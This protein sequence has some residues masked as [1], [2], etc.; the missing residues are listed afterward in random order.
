MSEAEASVHPHLPIR[1]T[2]REALLMEEVE[3]NW[4]RWQ[5][6]ARLPLHEEEIR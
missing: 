2:V 5:V 3:P 4:G 1:S 6:R